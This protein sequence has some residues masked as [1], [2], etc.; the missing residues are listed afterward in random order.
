MTMNTNAVHDRPPSRT[1]AS[2]EHRA[3]RIAALRFASLEL[4]P[5]AWSAAISEDARLDELHADLAAVFDGPTL[6]LLR[7][8]LPRAR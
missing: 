1:P 8:A 7:A 2:Q 4:R 5:D 3:R 6:A